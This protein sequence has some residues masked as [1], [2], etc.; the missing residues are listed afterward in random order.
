M[1]HKVLVSDKQVSLKLVVGDMYFKMLTLPGGDDLFD[2]YL[3]ESVLDCM[4]RYILLTATG[5]HKVVVCCV[6]M[7]RRYRVM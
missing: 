5:Q 6:L 2:I 7:G 1:I 3:F 4:Q